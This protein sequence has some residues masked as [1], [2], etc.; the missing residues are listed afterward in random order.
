MKKKQPSHAVF[1][2]LWELL[3]FIFTTGPNASS[4]INTSYYFPLCNK[5]DLD[6]IRQVV[7]NLKVIL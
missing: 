6:V 4:S 2:D 7:L 5:P 1:S 3:I